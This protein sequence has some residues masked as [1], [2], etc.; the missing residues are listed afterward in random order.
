[1]NIN[2]RSNKKDSLASD[3]V[4]ISEIT[5]NY[6]SKELIKNSP[7]NMS[8]NNRYGFIGKNGCGKTTLLKALKDRKL[9]IHENWL[10]L[11]VEQE[12]ED[13]DLNP[14]QFILN[15]NL[16]LLKIKE[17]FKVIEAK[18]EKDILSDEDMEEYELLQNKLN[19][20]EESKQEPIIKKILS[21]LGFTEKDMLKE[22]NKFSG[23]WKMRISL[24]KSLYMNPDILLLDEP[25]N[26]LDLEAVIW[27][28]SYLRNWKNIAVIVSHNVGFLN[29]VCTNIWNIE[30]KKI[31]TYKEIITLLK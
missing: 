18:M 9:P 19:S 2:Y 31:V 25:T 24:A 1:M 21:G 10:I 30:D 4:S 29:E 11:Y 14:V 5:I 22:C 12:I 26:H 17:K 23:G 27:L 3:N 28:G 16:R 15:S 6:G 20:F 13:T 7:L 8:K